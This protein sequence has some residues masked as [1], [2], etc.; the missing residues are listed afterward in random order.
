MHA[1]HATR[2]TQLRLRRLPQCICRN[3]VRGPRPLRLQ[4]HQPL[5]HRQQVPAAGSNIARNMPAGER[6]CSVPGDALRACPLV[7]ARHPGSGQ[8]NFD[9]ILPD[10]RPSSPGALCLVR[11][12]PVVRLQ[13]GKRLLRCQRVPA[14]RTRGCHWKLPDGEPAQA[15]KCHGC[16]L[17][18]NVL[19]IVS[20]CHVCPTFNLLYR[21]LLPP[22]QCIALAT[23]GCA[24]S[25][26][27]CDARLCQKEALNSAVG[28]CED[29]SCRCRQP[30]AH[31][32]AFGSPG[33]AAFQPPCTA[34][35]ART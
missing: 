18:S 3:A 9:C 32:A 8:R 31:F 23:S 17:A 26:N 16:S 13:C 12:T 24:S 34:W 27:C 14:R 5:L 15:A 19:L 21:P 4:C 22:M 35:P 28:T 33:G 11:S 30:L 7:E 25:Q 2:P 6:A 29:V 1:L 10:S 20:F